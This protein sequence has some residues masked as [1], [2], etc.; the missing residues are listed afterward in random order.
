MTVDGFSVARMER[1]FPFP[2]GAEPVEAVLN[3]VAAT[4]STLP[5]P[6]ARAASNTAF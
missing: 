4:A 2:L 6:M 1:S 3:A 5:E